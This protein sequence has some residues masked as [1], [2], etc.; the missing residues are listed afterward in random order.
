MNQ[1]FNLD[2]GPLMNYIAFT[3]ILLFR[4]AH[5]ENWLA[6]TFVFKRFF[7]QTQSSSLPF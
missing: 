2:T 5:L 1:L 6:Y 3:F 4:A 7:L